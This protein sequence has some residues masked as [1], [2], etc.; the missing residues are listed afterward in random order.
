MNATLSV[1]ALLA[2]LAIGLVVLG[3]ITSLPA[4]ATGGGEEG[5]GLSDFHSYAVDLSMSPAPTQGAASTLTFA[6][7][8]ITETGLTEYTVTVPDYY[9]INGGTPEGFTI[10]ES[11]D[12][13]EITASWQLTPTTGVTETFTL[14]VTPTGPSDLYDS[15]S[16]AAR[17]ITAT[18]PYLPV[19]V[20]LWALV[21][22]G[23]GPSG[24]VAT[25]RPRARDVATA[26]D[27]Q[28]Y[29]VAEDGTLTPVAGPVS[30]PTWMKPLAVGF[31]FSAP[32]EAG[33]PVSATLLISNTLG[34][35]VSYSGTVAFPQDWTVL[36]G[37]ATFAEALAPDGL[38]ARDYLVQPDA[39]SW[40]WSTTINL[41]LDEGLNQAG[42][43]DYLLEHDGGINTDGEGWL[44]ELSQLILDEGVGD[45][46]HAGSRYPV[47]LKF[48]A[49]DSLN[50]TPSNAECCPPIVAPGGVTTPQFRLKGHVNLKGRE[51]GM[52]NEV[53]P[54]PK[55]YVGG[56]LRI[57]VLKQ[58]RNPFYPP[59]PPPPNNSYWV[60]L[61]RTLTDDRGNFNLC[62]P[63][64]QILFPPGRTP[65]LWIEVASA[66]TVEW[67]D[68]LQWDEFSIATLHHTGGDGYAGQTSELERVY[69]TGPVG[70]IP[71]CE[72]GQQC[73]CSVWYAAVDHGVDKED[74][75]R[76]LFLTSFIAVD[77][78]KFM[79]AGDHTAE[80]IHNRINRFGFP[81]Y[82]FYGAPFLAPT[83]TAPGDPQGAK[84]AFGWDPG[85]AHDWSQILIAH[86]YFHHVHRTVALQ[87]SGA[88]RLSEG[89]ADFFAAEMEGSYGEAG[90]SGGFRDGGTYGWVDYLDDY[91][92]NPFPCSPHTGYRETGAWFMD[93]EDTGQ[94]EMDGCVPGALDEMDDVMIRM[95]SLIRNNNLQDVFDRC[96]TTGPNFYDGWVSTYGE[97]PELRVVSVHHRI[98]ADA[99]ECP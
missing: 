4:V 76:P 45:G 40:S 87:G 63:A 90:E 8:A 32:P 52:G 65:G 68:P 95:Y 92:G 11:V 93:L 60:D 64:N 22:Q 59:G 43:M 82:F 57:R 28:L 74:A 24:D 94:D 2:L 6:A 33:I 18:Y 27:I 79:A 98:L 58:Y 67:G 72:P 42:F 75:T 80:N 69:G 37:E 3:A 29:E 61:G 35:T 84:G 88:K 49:A 39:A 51:T 56:D 54:L 20:S 31:H 96:G 77:I 55:D 13:E 53:S 23:G 34:A 26:T 1:F 21:A 78:R 81:L 83:Y 86:E 15:I 30:Q 73:P 25:A 5:C 97:T 16:A 41:D 91:R 47:P 10:E 70:P 62:I 44:G 66:D 89:F 17:D 38:I 50:G 71:P 9:E 85:E 14:T 48:E 12:L 36:E 99:P 19:R 7:S 46:I